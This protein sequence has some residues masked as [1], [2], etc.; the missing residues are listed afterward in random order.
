[1]DLGSNTT[2]ESLVSQSV[3]VPSNFKKQSVAGVCLEENN[4]EINNHLK[5]VLHIMCF[6][7]T[8]YKLL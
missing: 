4:E 6:Y 7:K 5:R 8:R 2:Y 3:S 1:M